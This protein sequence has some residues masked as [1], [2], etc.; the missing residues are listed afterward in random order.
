MIRRTL[1]RSIRAAVRRRA[2]RC[3]PCSE[4][5]QSSTST[6]RHALLTLLHPLRPLRRQRCCCSLATL[7][8]RARAFTSG[9]LPLTAHPPVESGRHRERDRASRRLAGQVGHVA[10]QH[11]RRGVECC[12]ALHSCSQQGAESVIMCLAHNGAICDRLKEALALEVPCCPRPGPDAS[13]SLRRCVP[14]CVLPM[15]SQR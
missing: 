9:T 4:S 3:A 10:R 15:P 11:A 6:N 14:T 5:A 2:W 1:W 8:D 7:S 13:A 12:V